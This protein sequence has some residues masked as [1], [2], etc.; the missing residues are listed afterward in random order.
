[1]SCYKNG[2][3]GVY[4]NRSCSECPASKLEY[5]NKNKIETIE[6]TPEYFARMLTDEE[7]VQ[8]VSEALKKLGISVKTEYGNYRPLYDVLADI[9]KCWEQLK[10]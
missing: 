5:L 10:V 7:N 1:M 3:C 4:E 8:K 2:G 6:A 9:G